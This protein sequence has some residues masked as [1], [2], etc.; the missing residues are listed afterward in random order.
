MQSSLRSPDEPGRRVHAQGEVRKAVAQRGR[1][2]RD[3]GVVVIE[4]PR[5]H[6]DGV[7]VKTH[8]TD[9]LFEHDLVG[10]GLMQLGDRS[11]DLVQEDEAR[12]FGGVERPPGRVG[13]ERVLVLVG[14]P[15]PTQVYRIALG[16]SD[17]DQR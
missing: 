2:R 12:A 4:V 16:Q 17:V 10:R 1:Q 5:G 9:A 7:G 13:L 6:N 8:F 3:D 15:H 11:V 14:E